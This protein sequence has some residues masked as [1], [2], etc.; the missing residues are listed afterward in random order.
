MLFRSDAVDKALREYPQGLITCDLADA[1]LAKKLVELAEQE[2][3]VVLGVN[4]GDAAEGIATILGLGVPAEQL[5]R[6]LLGGIGSRLVCKLCPKCREEYLPAVDELAAVRIDAAEAVTFWRAPQDGCEVCGGTGYLGRTGVFEVA[7]GRTL[8]HYVAKAADTGTLRKAAA[9]DGMVS[10]A[11]AA[12]GL[13][14]AGV[15]SL[16]EVRRVMASGG[17]KQPRAEQPAR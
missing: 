12:I 1:D 4:A 8:Q 16:D 5:S 17:T 10:L 14:K 3:F 15:T 9:K 7:S 11:A 6:L 13:V 2:K